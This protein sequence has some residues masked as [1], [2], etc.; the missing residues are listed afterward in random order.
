MYNFCYRKY[1]KNSELVVL[2]AQWPKEIYLQRGWPEFFMKST[3]LFRSPLIFF[4]NFLAGL[5]HWK[6]QVDSWVNCFEYQYSFDWIKSE[7][8]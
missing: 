6:K 3:I 7:M 1:F 8:F 2:T 5:N 4:Q